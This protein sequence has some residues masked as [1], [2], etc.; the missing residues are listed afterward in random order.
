MN[1]NTTI[2]LEEEQK[3]TL[4][5]VKGITAETPKKNNSSVSQPSISSPTETPKSTV[6]PKK[7]GYST[8]DK[9]TG[10]N[11][12]LDLKNAYADGEQVFNLNFGQSAEAKNLR[13]QADTIRQTHNLS[14]EK[15]GS[16][17]TSQDVL[18]YYEVVNELGQI[19]AEFEEKHA[20]DPSFAQSEEGLRLAARANEIR[21]KYGLSD[22]EYGSGVTAADVLKKAG[23]I[24]E[25]Y[26]VKQS[27]E[28]AYH[29]SPQAQAIRNAADDVRTE[30]SLPDEQFGS[31]VTSQDVLKYLKNMENSPSYQ[32]DL[33]YQKYDETNRQLNEELIRELSSEE[34]MRA[35]M[36][37]IQ[38]QQIA[39]E[40]V[41]AQLDKEI[42]DSLA[43]E[44]E[45]AA[46]RGSY[47]QLSYGKRRAL[48]EQQLLDNRN[49]R[50][51]ALV[52]SLIDE[53]RQKAE[54]EYKEALARK[55]N[56][57]NVIGQK[58]NQNA[59]DFQLGQQYRGEL[60]QEAAA[61]Q[62]AL[63]D[64]VKAQYDQAFEM[65]NALGYITPELSELT[66][67]EAGTPMLKM[68]EHYGDLEKFYANL[69]QQALFNAANL[70]VAQYNAETDRI[71]ATRPQYSYGGYSGGY[72]GSYFNSDDNNDS[73]KPTLTPDAASAYYSN[74]CSEFEEKNGRKPTIDDLVSALDQSGLSIDDQIAIY[75]ATEYSSSEI[76]RALSIDEKH[77]QWDIDEVT[78]KIDN[79]GGSYMF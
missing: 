47:G 54:Q 12:V 5:K 77:A 78:G 50:V 22:E 28:N 64:T 4:D 27:Y 40:Q 55:E 42:G 1:R 29:N 26:G 34:K 13:T 76:E 44:D 58:M 57:V 51:Q 61:R 71:Y 14:D 48:K 68:V 3:R 20:L 53:D 70:E 75:N 36:D 17:V 46:Q 31:N 6:Q 66:G 21:S 35:V 8:L 72:S 23:A 18:R 25:L 38:A 19:K 59:A 63:Y 15:Y 79:P 24:H 56:R 11:E 69:E 45:L 74:F 49:A 67:I 7:T 2:N 65:S 41:G 30:F 33:A 37:R 32:R 73:G 52:Q 10:G 60:S 39:E 62:Q 9:I 43:Y 16:G